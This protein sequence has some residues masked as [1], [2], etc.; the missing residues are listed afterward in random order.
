MTSAI[1]V[2]RFALI[3]KEPDGQALAAQQRQD[4]GVFAI[5]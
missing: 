2:A 3:F 5:S 1:V 4:H